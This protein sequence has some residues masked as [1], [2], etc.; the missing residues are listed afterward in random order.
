MTAIHL[1]RHKPSERA[2]NEHVRRK[3]LL[4]VD[5]RRAYSCRHSVAQKPHVRARVFVRDHTRNRPCHR[6]VLRGERIVAFPEVSLVVVLQRTFP[7]KGIL[8]RVGVLPWR[9]GP[10]QWQ[11]NL[12]R[13]CDRRA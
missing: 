6:R 5:A 10:L 4:G 1:L 13:V 12:S 3:M 8:E 2:S 9:S 7:P 11:E